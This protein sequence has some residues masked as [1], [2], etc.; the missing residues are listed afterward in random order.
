MSSDKLYRYKFYIYTLSGADQ[1]GALWVRPPL[2]IFKGGSAP[3]LKLFGRKT[4]FSVCVL[5]NNVTAYCP[6][7]SLLFS[8]R[9]LK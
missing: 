7:I 2:G 5:N 8:Y 4:R 6:I 9:Y 1:G 3:P